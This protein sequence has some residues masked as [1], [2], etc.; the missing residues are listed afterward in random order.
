MDIIE[1]FKLEIEKVVTVKYNEDMS[2]HCSFKLGG[3]AFCFCEPL[4]IN[5]LKKIINLCEQFNIKYIIVGKCSNLVFRDGGYQG[6]VISLKYFNKIQKKKNVIKV[7]AGTNLF[8]LNMFA[9]EHSLMGLEFSF[10][11]PGSVGGAVYMNAGAYGKEFKDIIESVSFL[12]DGKLIT[13]NC[14]DI[15]FDYRYSEFQKSKDIIIS[16]NLNLQFGKKEDIIYLQ[17]HYFSKRKFSQPLNYPSAGS[18]FKR[19]GT[20]LPAKIIDELGLK[21]TKIGG[22]EISTKH[23]G[24]IVNV[25]N[26]T[27]NH[28][29]TLVDFI[30]NKVYEKENIKLQTEIIFIGDKI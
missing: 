16:V 12:R 4:N 14:K 9:R 30:I 2:K 7:D 28:L 15:N 23:S 13:K 21:G 6:V 10:G 29:E 5:E 20:V 11:I 19:M 26:G 1:G 8:A 17:N 3:K 25:D 27:A 22:V 24:F 18:V